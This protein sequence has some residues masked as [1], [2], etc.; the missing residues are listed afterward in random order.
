MAWN[1]KETLETPRRMIC[2]RCNVPM[3]K[4]KT[5]FSYLTFT[6]HTE[7][8][9][10]PVCRQVFVPEELVKGRMS[11]VEAELEDK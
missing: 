10:C 9:R 11:R 8:L 1:D 4:A 2:R 5:G 6:F 7:L 3:E